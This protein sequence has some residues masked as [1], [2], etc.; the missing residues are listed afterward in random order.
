MHGCT[1]V[2]PQLRVLLD[3]KVV[4]M[5]LRH[6]FIDLFFASL[7]LD[8]DC[9]PDCSHGGLQMPSV[10]LFTQATEGVIAGEAAV[11]SLSL[12]NMPYLAVLQGKTLHQ[13]LQE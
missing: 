6:T 9:P 1:A 7:N 8:L 3:E 5:W 4:A 12:A 10:P 13:L 2:W 11:L